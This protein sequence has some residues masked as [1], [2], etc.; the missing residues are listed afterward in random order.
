[1]YDKSEYFLRHFGFDYHLKISHKHFQVALSQTYF[2][3]TSL[4]TIGF[5]DFHPRSDYERMMGSTILLLGVSMFS[6]IMSKFIQMM[7]QINET[8]KEMD[9]TVDLSNFFITLKYFNQNKDLPQEFT[10]K[11]QNYFLYRWNNDRNMAIKEDEDLDI[12]T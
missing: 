2:A 7:D 8:N 1:M 6:Y 12:L 4:T 9:E 11:L 5:G 10:T 3:F